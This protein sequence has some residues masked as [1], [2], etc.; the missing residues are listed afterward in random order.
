MLNLIYQISWYFFVQ[1]QNWPCY[2]Q[3]PV[4][5]GENFNGFWALAGSFWNFFSKKISDSFSAIQYASF[6]VLQSIFGELFFLGSYKGIRKNYESYLLLT[7]LKKKKKKKIFFSFTPNRK[8][9]K[10]VLIDKSLKGAKKNTLMYIV[11]W[12]Y[13]CC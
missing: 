7:L 10:G 2:N 3:K 1:S 4:F 9:K 6:G 12:T 8:G 11:Q 13:I 5:L